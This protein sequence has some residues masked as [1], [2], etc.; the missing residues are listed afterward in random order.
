M[1]QIHRPRI[2][3]PAVIGV[4]LLDEI[5]GTL[6]IDCMPPPSVI[7]PLMA[8][9]DAHHDENRDPEDDRQLVADTL[10]VLDGEW[11]HLEEIHT[12]Q[13]LRGWHRARY[14]AITVDAW[15]LAATR[16]LLDN[17]TLS[18]GSECDE[19]LRELAYPGNEDLL[20]AAKRQMA[21]TGYCGEC[22][23]CTVLRLRDETDTALDAAGYEGG[24]YY[25]AYCLGQSVEQ[26][27]REV[28]GR[29]AS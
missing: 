2:H 6:C 13:R 18:L 8:R 10:R 21:R 28:Y 17:L 22:Q 9:A 15:W 16:N 1:G 12:V 23:W 24:V 19:T 29:C 14:G 3:G 5:E 11:L 4:S 20:A 27:N 25:R 26:I 7:A